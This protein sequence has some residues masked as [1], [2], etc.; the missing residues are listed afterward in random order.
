[1]SDNIIRS[2]IGEAL[3]YPLAEEAFALT[4]VIEANVS[5]VDIANVDLDDTAN[6]IADTIVSV[7]S[8]RSTAILLAV[9]G[10]AGAYEEE[11]G[12][13]YDGTTWDCIVA[14]VSVVVVKAVRAAL[15]AA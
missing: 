7:L 11:Y 2:A 1:M 3:N 10:A 4:D 9:L 14:D 12:E 13:R 6:E 15:E 5:E 8:V